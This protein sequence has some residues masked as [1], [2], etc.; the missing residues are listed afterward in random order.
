MLIAFFMISNEVTLIRNHMLA[1]Y[2]NVI[3]DD[4]LQVKRV[5]ARV[6]ISHYIRSCCLKVHSGYEFLSRAL[7]SVECKDI[8]AKLEPA[9]AESLS[10]LRKYF[11]RKNAIHSVRNKFAGH[12]D[13][14]AFDTSPGF[15][16]DDTSMFFEVNGP[17]RVNSLYLLPEYNFIQFLREVYESRSQDVDLIGKLGVEVDNVATLLINVVEGLLVALLSTNGILNTDDMIQD[18]Y[19]VDC[20]DLTATQPFYFVDIDNAKQRSLG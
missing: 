9:Q 4:M 7:K 1:A 18:L 3:E 15:D 6:A 13:H 20:Q 10:A 17:S 8:V 19:D 2:F 11:S 5:A 12:F 16:V 14:D